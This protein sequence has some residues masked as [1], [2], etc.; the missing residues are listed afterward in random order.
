MMHYRKNVQIE[1]WCIYIVLSTLYISIVL[2][3]HGIAKYH[4]NTSWKID[5]TI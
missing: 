1:I 3:C 4:P 2:V 5:A